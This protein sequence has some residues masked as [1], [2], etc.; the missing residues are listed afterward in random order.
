MRWSLLL[1][2]VREG[3]ATSL[4]EN[5]RQRQDA[6][7]HERRRQQRRK[8]RMTTGRLD[9]DVWMCLCISVARDSVVSAATA[10]AAGQQTVRSDEGPSG[11]KAGHSSCDHAGG[12][13]DG[14]SRLMKLISM[15]YCRRRAASRVRPLMCGGGNRR[16]VPLY[17]CIATSPLS[18]TV[19]DCRGD[20]QEGLLT[21]FCRALPHSS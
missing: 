14:A 17:S 21:I 4:E 20:Y 9:V 7:K 19:A 16:W 11:L 18:T 6:A 8:M 3:A 2:L 13:R 15:D 10:A 1:S 5:G 12:A